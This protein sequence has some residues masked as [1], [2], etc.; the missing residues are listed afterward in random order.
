[1]S[2]AVPTHVR[3][4]ARAAARRPGPLG[5]LLLVWGVWA[6]M[7]TFAFEQIAR[8]GRNVP[9]SEDWLM[10]PALTGHQPH[11]WAWVW[12]QNNEHR[13]PVPRLV[14][15]GLLELTGDF[16]VGM[17]VNAIVLGVLA[18]AMILVARR[19]R[20]GRTSYLDAFF[21]VVVLNLGHWENLGWSWQLSFVLSVAAIVGILLVLV[22]SPV[23]LGRA[24]AVALAAMLVLLPL[25]GAT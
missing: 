17:V 14:Y 18:A 2:V 11:F 6:V 25:T 7:L 24:P 9:L 8:V 5:P 1:M 3:E 16:R 12:S 19:L 10:V 23:P 20:G 21:P 13:L 22:A 15:L 4:D